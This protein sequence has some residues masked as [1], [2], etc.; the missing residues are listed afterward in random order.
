LW[1][2]AGYDVSRLKEEDWYRE[3]GTGM[4]KTLQIAEEFGAYTLTDIGT[5]LKYSKEGLV[6]S[7]VIV[8]EGE[9]LIN[10]YSA[11]A[12]DPD[13]NSDA[14]F[15]S[16]MKF[17]EYL[18]SEEGQIIFEEFGVDEY[19]SNLFN[20]VINLLST[21]QDPILV[22]WIKRAGFFRGEECPSEFQ[23]GEYNLYN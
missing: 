7:E 9:E 13:A 10:I 5:F 2:Q 21:N 18:V 1:T 8:G 20:S 17:I 6:T 16:A 3:A 15:D 4:G 14:D 11:L 19:G 23:Q 22:E 12:V